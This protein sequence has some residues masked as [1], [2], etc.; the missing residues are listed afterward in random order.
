VHLLHGQLVSF[1]E[2][3]VDLLAVLLR[4]WCQQ[5]VAPPA[6]L[7]VV[8]PVVPVLAASAAD[9]AIHHAVGVG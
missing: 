8:V 1:D 3:V 2:H 9:S 7:G 6:G 5:L 4:L